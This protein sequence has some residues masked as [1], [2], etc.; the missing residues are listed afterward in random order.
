MSNPDDCTKSVF[1]PGMHEKI[2][3]RFPRFAANV[4]RG[5][6]EPIEHILEAASDDDISRIEQR[7]GIPLPES[8]KAFLRCT[9]GFWAMGGIVQLNSCHPYF[10]EFPSF[11]KLT[12]IQKSAV[13]QQGGPW[14]PPSQG[15]LCFAELSMEADG[16]QLLFDVSNGLVD[17]EYPVY[18]YAHEG[19]PASIRKLADS[20]EQWLN[21]FLECEAFQNEDKGYIR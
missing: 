10:H 6:G 5:L 19:A 1:D 4:E 3:N 9:R 2:Y 18:Y 11:E 17:D 7:L 15:M 14:P 13:R 8:Y 16:D 20:F 21:E 12:E